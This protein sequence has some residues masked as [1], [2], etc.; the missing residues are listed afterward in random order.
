MLHVGRRMIHLDGKGVCCT[1][2]AKRSNVIAV[3]GG[4]ARLARANRNPVKQN[5][6]FFGAL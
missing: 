4:V 3:R 2:A 5:A 1:R 6:R